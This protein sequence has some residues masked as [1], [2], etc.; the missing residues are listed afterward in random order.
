MKAWVVWGHLSSRVTILLSSEQSERINCGNRG[1]SSE[2]GNRKGPKGKQG[3]WLS[4]LLP[5]MGSG[6]TA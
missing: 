1:K 2:T 6:T 5:E 4:F 3:N